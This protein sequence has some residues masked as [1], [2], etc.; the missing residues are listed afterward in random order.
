MLRKHPQERLLD[1][2][3]EA[4]AA[5][6]PSPRQAKHAKMPFPQGRFGEEEGD[7]VLAARLVRVR[8]R[9]E[10]SRLEV[11]EAT[12]IPYESL[13]GYEGG[14]QR[15]PFC[16]VAILALFYGVSL[17]WLGGLSDETEGGLKTR[18]KNL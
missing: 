15:A 11:A 4:T 12:G 16:R 18:K 2:P 1:D 8:K 17:D 14:H 3:S 13:G 5:W 9:K 6:S 7:K 10:F